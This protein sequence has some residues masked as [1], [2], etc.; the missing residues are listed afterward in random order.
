[1]QSVLIKVWCWWRRR[2]Q[3]FIVWRWLSAGLWY[4]DYGPPRHALSPFTWPPVSLADYSSGW[5]WCN[6][7]F[8]QDQLARSRTK[9][10]KH[11]IWNLHCRVAEYR[12]KERFQL[13]SVFQL[14]STGYFEWWDIC[15]RLPNRQREQKMKDD[16]VPLYLFVLKSQ[17]SCSL[18]LI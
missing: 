3:C 1:M 7:K 14:L 18:A 8:M 10:R 5:S 15:E 17:Q 12:A 13:L 16:H 4:Y 2:K 9:Q 6:W 11:R